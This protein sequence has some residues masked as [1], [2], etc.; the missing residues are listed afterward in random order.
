M[1]KGYLVFVLHA[2]LPF[3]RHPEHDNFLEERWLY[4]AISETYLPLL[5]V[6]DRLDADGVPFKLTISISPTLS[7]MLEDELLMERY[8]KH[9]DKLLELCEK[10]LVRTAGDTEYYPLARMY[11]DLYRDNRRDFTEKYEKKNPSRL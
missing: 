11:R 5:R 10:E 7:S 3:V 2:H 6:F 4:E 9:V 8:I 1:N